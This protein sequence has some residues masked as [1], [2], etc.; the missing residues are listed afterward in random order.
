MSTELILLLS[1]P[2]VEG[3]EQEQWLVIALGLVHTNVISAMKGA[4]CVNNII[5]WC[6]AANVVLFGKVVCISSCRCRI[7][8][9][10]RGKLCCA[11]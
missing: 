6:A 8:F 3:K 5:H 7:A 2:E 10:G 4:T 9:Q 1:M 11:I